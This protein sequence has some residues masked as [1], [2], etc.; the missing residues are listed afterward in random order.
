MNKALRDRI[1]AVKSQLKDMMRPKMGKYHFDLVKIKELEDKL[2]CLK[3][4]INSI[5]KV[6][7]ALF[8]KLDNG[9]TASFHQFGGTIYSTTSEG[10]EKKDFEE[11]KKDIVKYDW[12]VE[13]LE[14]IWVEK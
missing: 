6:E 14:E 5:E 13:K 12:N 8:V 2:K 3:M 1:N 9:E 7:S 11:F 10:L 4:K